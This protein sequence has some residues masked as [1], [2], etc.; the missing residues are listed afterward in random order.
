MHRN[1]GVD[2]KNSAWHKVTHRVFLLWLNTFAFRA[3]I[4][5]NFYIKVKMLVQVQLSFFLFFS[6]VQTPPVSDM[7]L[8]LLWKIS[9]PRQAWWPTPAIPALGRR[10]QED[11][12]FEASVGYMP[13]PCLKAD[14]LKE[15]SV[16]FLHGGPLLV[17][18]PAHL[19]LA[20]TALS[21][22]QW[23]L[24]PGSASPSFP[25]CCLAHVPYHR[26][27]GTSSPMTRRAL[28]HLVGTALSVDESGGQSI[29]ACWVCHHGHSCVTWRLPSVVSCP[30]RFTS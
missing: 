24:Q 29:T 28:G 18:W 4:Y 22:S 17:R 14:P 6:G 7:Y 16:D 15:N 20:N 11:L 19:D 9:R 13:R 1:F 8:S 10:R 30:V 25:N 2:L 12:E 3:M 21:W 26:G 27:F 23:T 5:F